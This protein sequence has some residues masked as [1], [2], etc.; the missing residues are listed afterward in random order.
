[1]LNYRTFMTQADSICK[2]SSLLYS[3]EK[4]STAKHPKIMSFKEKQIS[5]ENTLEPRL[6]LDNVHLSGPDT[7]CLIS[8]TRSSTFGVRVWADETLKIEW[9][10]S[11]TRRR[12]SD[13]LFSSVRENSCSHRYV[14]PNIDIVWA[15]GALC[16]EWS[17]QTQQRPQ[18]RIL[19]SVCHYIGYRSILFV[20]VRCWVRVAV[21][22]WNI[23]MLQ[24]IVKIWLQLLRKRPWGLVL[25]TGDKCELKEHWEN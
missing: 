8:C 18:D 24:I 9:M 16:R 3:T 14:L 5:Y 22:T 1:M 15:A 10:C 25:F 21:S 19:P 17:V 23:F 20:C 4:K 7:W 12:L 2:F 13:V 6:L 11:S